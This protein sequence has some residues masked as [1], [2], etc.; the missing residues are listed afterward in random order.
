MKAPYKEARRYVT[1]AE[2][3]LQSKAGRDNGLYKDKKYVKMAGDIAYK[4]VLL[5]VEEWL[6]SK[7][8]ERP[9]KKRPSKEWYQVELSK[10]HRKLNSL[11]I[12]AY[13]G[14]HLYMGYDGFPLVRS[15]KDWMEI[16]KQIIS[17][18]DKDS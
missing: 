14:L 9:G 5:A 7:G 15:A 2:E 16:A 1:N 3:L 8:V 11:F 10:R 12:V 6:K 17:L 13:D 18:C 4:G